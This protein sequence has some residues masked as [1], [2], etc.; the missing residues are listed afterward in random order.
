MEKPSAVNSVNLPHTITKSGDGKIQLDDPDTPNNES[1]LLQENHYYPFGMVMEGEWT[2]QVGER[3]QYQYNGKEIDNDLGLDWYH[4]GFRMYDAGIGRWNAVDPIASDF[5]HVTTY[6]YA[7]NE[8]VGHIDLWGLQQTRYEMNQDRKFGSKEYARKTIE[9]RQEERKTEA[10]VIAGGLGIATLGAVGGE[11]ALPLLANPL[12]LETSGTIIATN[13]AADGM[14]QTVTNIANGEN[15]ITNYDIVGGAASALSNPVVSNLIDGA[16]DVTLNGV[17][18]NSP[19]NT[20][21]QTVVGGGLGKATSP[22]TDVLDSAQNAM[23]SFVNGVLSLFSN[24]AKAGANRAV[25]TIK[26]KDE[27]K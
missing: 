22:V 6:N 8:P 25:D 2:P 18:L 16:V 19:E 3:N 9:Q 12:T 20:L 5:P 17:K 15:P 10:T 14:I 1:E 13:V 26:A 24:V 23:A 7:E 27:K 11:A 21:T 4:Y